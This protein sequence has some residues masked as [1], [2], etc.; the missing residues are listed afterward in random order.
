[1]SSKILYDL[2]NRTN[3][4]YWQTNRRISPQDQKTIFLDRKNTVSAKDTKAA[5]EFGMQQIDKNTKVTD[6]GNPIPF[7]SV[8]NVL[9][10]TLSDK[11]RVVVRMHP[12]FVQN[13]YFWTEKIITDLVRSAH[14]PT[15]KTLYIDDSKHTFNFDYMI[16]SLV[17]GKPLE[18]MH[19]ISDSLDKK[20]IEETGKFIAMFH[21]IKT[22]GFGFFKNDIAKA[23]N[24]LQGQYSTFKEHIFAGIEEDFTFLTDSKVLT[25]KQAKN[26]D[27]VLNAHDDLLSISQ[28]VLIH[29]DL[30]DWNELSDGEHITGIMDWDESFSGDPIMDFAQ[31]SLFY[32]DDRLEHLI[33]GYKQVKELPD[34]FK[35]KLHL[36]KLRY[37]VSKLHLRKK[38]AIAITDSK[39]LNERIK[40]GVEVLEEE[41]KYF[42]IK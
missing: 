37:V 1:M 6:L 2:S 28:G 29:N 30:A 24:R 12:Y 22:N 38:R 39:F 3:M 42:G 5:I 13:G 40:R 8:N 15:Y 17:P 16:M 18:E 9:K 41:L 26:I 7:G 36:F 11:T 4:F 21:N 25:P 19:P 20:L 32:N 23:E 31:W 27:S 34:G 35:D 33:A 10:A 14:V